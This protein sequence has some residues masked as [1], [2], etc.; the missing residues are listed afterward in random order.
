VLLIPAAVVTALFSREVL[1]LLT[2]DAAAV[3]NAHLVLTL[4]AAGMLLHGLF[5]APYYM[6]L[7]YGRWRL[8]STTNAVLVATIL[9]LYV[10]AGKMYGAV[11][12]ASV[13]V[14]LNVAWAVTMPLMH[15]HFVR[16]EER[17]W[18]VHDVSLPLA[19]ALGAAAVAFVLLPHGTGVVH[20]LLFLGIAGLVTLGA[21]AA[22]ASDIRSLLVPYLRQS[23]PT[24]AA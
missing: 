15:R 7:A 17:R 2:R 10:I 22:M 3:R 20:L 16:G 4:L 24:E 23:A 19:G 18:L 21:T 14:L 11:G 12:A 1:T 5:Q 9:P 13:L 6:Q 8:I